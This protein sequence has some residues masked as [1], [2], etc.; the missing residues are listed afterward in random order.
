M[1][2]GSGAGCL[3]P[4]LLLLHQIALRIGLTTLSATKSFSLSVTTT[5]SFAPAAAAMIMSGR[6]RGLPAVLPSAIKRAQISPALSS[7]D[8]IRPA[9]IA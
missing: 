3:E 9:K 7:N 1:G 4:S 2:D 8:N 6:L 5:H